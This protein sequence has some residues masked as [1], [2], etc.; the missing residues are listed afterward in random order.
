MQ[1]VDVAKQSFHLLDKIGKEAFSLKSDNNFR[2]AFIYRHTRNIHELGADVVHLMATR[3]LASCPVIIRAMFESLFKLVTAVKQPQAAIE[4][5]I[6]EIEED[7]KRIEKWLDPIQCAQAINIYSQYA[8]QLRQENQVASNK[9]WNTEACAAAAEMSEK[10]RGEY[11]LFSAHAHASTSGIITQEMKANKGFIYQTLLFIVL[12]ATGHAPQVIPTKS[13][14]QNIDE[15]AKLMIELVRLM[16]SGIFDEMNEPVEIEDLNE[17]D[18]CLN[19]LL[20]L[21]RNS[22]RSLFNFFRVR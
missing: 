14:Q 12:Y 19:R 4:I 9:K 16:E 15:T 11:F 10:Y 7:R 21:F 8:Q 1:V 22:Y 20:N 13:P 18:G 5:F 17:S 6:Y 2:E 3:R